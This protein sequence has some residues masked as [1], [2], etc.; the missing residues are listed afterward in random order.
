[1]SR[2][3]KQ[4]PALTR[5]RAAAEASIRTGAYAARMAAIGQPDGAPP[6]HAGKRV[7]GLAVTAGIAKER[8]DAAQARNNQAS[9]ETGDHT[10]GAQRTTFT[11]ADG[12]QSEPLTPDQIAAAM[13]RRKAN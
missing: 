6:T 13:A 12:T 1:M 3:A 5:L 7:A 9:A 10:P 4:E 11:R 8:F 2:Q